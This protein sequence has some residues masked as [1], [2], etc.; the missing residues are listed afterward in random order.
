MVPEDAGRIKDMKNR[1]DRLLIE[2]AQVS[3]PLAQRGLKRALYRDTEDYKEAEAEGRLTEYLDSLSDIDVPPDIVNDV[4]NTMLELGNPDLIG[5]QEEDGGN[6][7]KKRRGQRRR[8]G[9][10]SKGKSTG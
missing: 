5:V 8:S 1:V 2:V 3:Y 6:K 7:K 4:V 9:S 10:S